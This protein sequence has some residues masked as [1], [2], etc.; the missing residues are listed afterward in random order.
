MDVQEA[1]KTRRAV[2]RYKSDAM[3]ED[4]LKRI[5]EAA[6]LAPSAKNKQD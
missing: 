3:P 4:S 6:R 2:R 1:I 5:L